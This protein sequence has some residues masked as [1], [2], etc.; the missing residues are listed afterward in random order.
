MAAFLPVLARI[1]TLV[2]QEAECLRDD[3]QSLYDALLTDYEPGTTEA[4]VA[5]IFDRL[6][7]GAG[8]IC[9]PACWKSRRRR[10]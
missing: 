6:R 1:V 2:R 10:R 5:N 9:V 7:T 4:E 8:Q 3:G